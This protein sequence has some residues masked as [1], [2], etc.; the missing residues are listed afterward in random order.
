[1]TP[2]FLGQVNKPNPHLSMSLLLCFGP[3]I[4]GPLLEAQ[5]PMFNLTSTHFPHS[6]KIIMVRKAELKKT[7][8][9]K[10][11]I[12]TRSIKFPKV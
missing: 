7:P 10:S 12:S 6:L 4:R 11:L 8:Y 9:L 2:I 3:E 5:D 1:M